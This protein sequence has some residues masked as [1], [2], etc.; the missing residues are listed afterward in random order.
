MFDLQD[1]PG[2]VTESGERRFEA[3]RATVGILFCGVVALGGSAILGDLGIGRHHAPISGR[4]VA[5]VGVIRPPEAS[6]RHKRPLWTLEEGRVSVVR[7]A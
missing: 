1:N 3:F 6:A 7:T 4:E 5:R 2:L